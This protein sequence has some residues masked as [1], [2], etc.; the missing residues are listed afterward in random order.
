M[1]LTTLVIL[2]AAL[3]AADPPAAPKVSE[4]APAD[5]LLHQ[6]NHYVE[7]LGESL[8][9]KEDYPAANQ[10]RVKKDANTLAVLGLALALH[11]SDHKL[12][13]SAGGLIQHAGELAAASEDYDKA[14]AAHEKLQKAA[15]G[16]VSDVA[17]PK[18]WQKV[19][20]QGQLMKQ[21]QLLYNGL[22]R[23]TDARRFKKQAEE[24]AGMAALLA[25]IAQSAIV[26]THEVKD[27]GQLPEW[28]KLSAEMR[29]SAAELNQAIHAGKQDTAVAALKRMNVSC[30]TCHKQFRVEVE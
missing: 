26:D 27:P 5:D 19:A 22:R 24:N 12:K 16:E 6:V 20:A 28:Y 23:G 18:Q 29:D 2:T 17:A 7:R 15:A 14:K 10:A 21:V 9:K 11:D 13:Q 25:V 8:A 1:T 30:E 4:F 3:I